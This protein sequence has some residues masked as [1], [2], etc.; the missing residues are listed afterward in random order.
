MKHGADLPDG[1]PLFL[2]KHDFRYTGQVLK[3]AYRRF[4]GPELEA[5]R[6]EQ[7][8]LCHDPHIT[9][10]EDRIFSAGNPPGA[11]G[12]EVDIVSDSAELGPLV[13]L[14]DALC[15]FGK[16]LLAHGGCLPVK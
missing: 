11:D 5:L 7:A 2:C 4:E 10:K 15:P 16:I 14:L 3:P 1:I 13:L 9:L 6:F 12:V 8:A